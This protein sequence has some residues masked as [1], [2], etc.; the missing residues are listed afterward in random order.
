[1]TKTTAPQ[2]AAVVLS[3]FLAL[4]TV[5]G[6]DALGSSQAATAQAQALVA[7]ARAG[8]VQTAAAQTVVVVG[9]RV[10]KA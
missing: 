10:A 6:V 9:R 2:A 8:L 3:A 7:A 5:A 1:M 4:A